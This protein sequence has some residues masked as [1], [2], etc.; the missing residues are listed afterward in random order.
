MEGRIRPPQ[1]A[2]MGNSPNEEFSERRIDRDDV[3]AATSPPASPAP[4]WSRVCRSV[5]TVRTTRPYFPA[6]GSRPVDTVN[7]HGPAKR[8]RIVP[9]PI[10]PF[11]ADSR[12]GPWRNEKGRVET[13]PDL[14]FYCAL[15]GNRTQNLRIKR[16]PKTVVFTG[17]SC[18][19]LGSSSARFVPD[20]PNCPEWSAVMHSVKHRQFS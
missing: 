12:Q 1:R 6:A 9:I 13:L 20:T 16:P 4:L 18:V 10:P 19:L 7:S 3:P 8:S 5:C 15:P 11:A 17:F 14:V 2:H